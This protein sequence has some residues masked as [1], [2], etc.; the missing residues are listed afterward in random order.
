M[1]IT[2]NYDLLFSIPLNRTMLVLID[3][4]N[5]LKILKTKWWKYLLMGLADVEANYAVVMAYQYTNLTSIQ[6]GG[7]CHTVVHCWDQCCP[8]KASSVD[9]L[10]L[11]LRVSAAGLLCDPSADATFLVLPKNTLQTHPLFSCGGVFAR[12]GGHGRSRHPCWKK[13]GSRRKKSGI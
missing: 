9:S 8:I 12:G 6:V 10:L 1:V 7:K 4:R 3:D 13:S 2:G 11:W 5:I